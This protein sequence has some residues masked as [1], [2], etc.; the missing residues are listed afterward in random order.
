MQFKDLLNNIKKLNDKSDKVIRLY[1]NKWY[2]IAAT[3]NLSSSPSAFI[4][5][6]GTNYANKAP[7]CLI[8]GGV[9]AY[10]SAKISELTKVIHDGSTKHIDKIRIQRSS[11]STI[12]YL[13]VHYSLS[14]LTNDLYLNFLEKDKFWRFTDS[15]EVI[16]YE[17]KVEISL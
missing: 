6:M 3:S 17:T 11:D 1:E 8:L 7:M 2:R 10:T 16:E 13:D 9:T 5:K 12:F 4:L 14:N 15:N